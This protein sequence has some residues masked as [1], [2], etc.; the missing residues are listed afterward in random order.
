MYWW[1]LYILPLAAILGASCTSGPWNRVHAESYRT[2]IG[3]DGTSWFILIAEQARSGNHLAWSNAYPENFEEFL[4]A[5]R[6]LIG[7]REFR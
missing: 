3:D 1:V 4:A 2:H 5:V 7:N 6:R